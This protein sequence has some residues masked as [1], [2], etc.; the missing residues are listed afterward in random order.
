[1]GD[2]VLGADVWAVLV[3]IGAIAVGLGVAAAGRGRLPFAVAMCWGL[4]WIA[5]G[6]RDGPDE[7][8]LVVVFAV[9]AAI[10][11][12]LGTLVARIGRSER[13]HPAGSP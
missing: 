13:L 9:A 8:M 7:S 10:L 6:R 4:A 5:V 3:L 2:L 12:A 1:M 11:V